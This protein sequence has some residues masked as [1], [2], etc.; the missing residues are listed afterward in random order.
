M[1]IEKSKR[2]SQE[3][4]Y[5]KQFEQGCRGLPIKGKGCLEHPYL[6]EVCAGPGQLTQDWAV[7]VEWTL[8]NQES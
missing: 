7:L 4:E 6:R 5:L 2:K 1:R 8:V 3:E